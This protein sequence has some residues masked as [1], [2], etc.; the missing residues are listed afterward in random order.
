[1]L[2]LVKVLGRV[3]VLR[4]IAAAD[5]P[6][7][8]THAEVDPGIAHL[9]AFFANM[10][11]GVFNLYVVEVGALFWHGGLQIGTVSRFR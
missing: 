3:L 8:Q 2:C 1:M 4:G 6:T 9:Y 11:V 10:L 7:L 5:L